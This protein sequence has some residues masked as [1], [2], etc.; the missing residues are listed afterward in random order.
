MACQFLKLFW[1][2]RSSPLRL[3]PDEDSGISSGVAERFKDLLFGDG[4]LIVVFELVRLVTF[5]GKPDAPSSAT[6]ANGI[7]VQFGGRFNNCGGRFEDDV[8]G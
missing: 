8:S 1:Y 5:M 7:I 2:S 6:G 3:M 4:S